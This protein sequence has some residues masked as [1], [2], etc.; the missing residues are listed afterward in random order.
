MPELKASHDFAV[1]AADV[2]ALLED[3][4]NLAAWWPTDGPVKIARVEKEGEG[5]GMVRHIHHVGVPVPLSEKLEYLDPAERVLKLSIVGTLP[6]GMQSYHGTG[7]V[8]ETGPESCRM[9]YSAEVATDS[10]KEKEV[11]GFLRFAWSLMFKGLTN[12]TQ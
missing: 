3:F 2:W 1:P 6:P 9:D 8:V 5:V 11:E 12:A 4:G 10:G 7:A